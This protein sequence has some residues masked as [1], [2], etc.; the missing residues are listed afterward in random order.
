MTAFSCSAIH[1]ICHKTGEPNQGTKSH[2]LHTFENLILAP[3][4]FACIHSL[5]RTANDYFTTTQ[6]TNLF[7]HLLLSSYVDIDKCLYT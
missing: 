2:G 6:A 7:I 1:Y 4:L 5:Q 3:T